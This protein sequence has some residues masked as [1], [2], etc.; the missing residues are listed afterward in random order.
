MID[1]QGLPV[2]IEVDGG[3]STRHHRPSLA[4]AGADVLVSGSGIYGGDG[5]VAGKRAALKELMMQAGY[6]AKIRR[7]HG[8]ARASGPG[9]RRP[10]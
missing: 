4:A 9:D 1:A 3:V 8:E 6:P 7:R 5:D 10:I 2:L